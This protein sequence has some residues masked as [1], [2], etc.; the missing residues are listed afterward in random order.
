[1]AK[2]ATPAKQEGPNPDP[3]LAAAPR[4]APKIDKAKRFKPKLAA[5][6]L[7]S[8]HP[9]L[10][11]ERSNKGV[12]P[13]RLG[14]QSAILIIALLPI[15]S[16]TALGQVVINLPAYGAVAEICGKV[17]MDEG[18]SLYSMIM[19]LEIFKENITHTKNCY[20]WAAAIIKHE[21]SKQPIPLWMNTDLPTTFSSSENNENR[22]GRFLPLLLGIAAVASA[23]LSDIYTSKQLMQIKSQMRI[24]DTNLR[25]L[26][27]TITEQHDQLVTIIKTTDSLYE[28]THKTFRTLTNLLNFNVKSIRNLRFCTDGIV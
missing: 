4:V 9:T 5:L 26:N 22:K 18:L 24:F 2:Q 6:L 28:Y 12:P 19:R 25:S 8:E 23:I 17:A 13:P 20:D 10:T 3:G 11:S 15:L 7:A 27:Y 14:F 21:I 1:M 16:G